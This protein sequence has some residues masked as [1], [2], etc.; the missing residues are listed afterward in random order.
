MTN[1]TCEARSR[2]PSM[3]LGASPSHSV[4]A[5]CCPCSVRSHPESYTDCQLVQACGVWCNE[6]DPMTSHRQPY[7]LAPIPSP[8]AL[9]VAGLAS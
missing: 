4:R 1:T 7:M 3:S 8:I 6:A 9:E 2:Q 5:S